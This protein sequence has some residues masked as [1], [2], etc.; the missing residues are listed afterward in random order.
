MVLEKILESPLDSKE[1]KP[2]NPKG[3]QPW[4]FI[5]RTDAEAETPVL[6]PPDAKNW[7]IGKDPDAGNDWR[8]EKGMTEDEMVGW[9]HRLNGH[10]F[11]QAPGDREAWH[12]AIHG[13]ANSQTQLSNWTTTVHLYLKEL[14]RPQPTTTVSLYLSSLFVSF[15]PFRAPYKPVYL[16]L[17][18]LFIFMFLLLERQAGPQPHEDHD[19]KGLDPKRN[20]EPVK[21]FK[22]G[23]KK[24]GIIL[25]IALWQNKWRVKNSLE[26]CK[27]GSPIRRLLGWPKLGVMMRWM[28]RW[29]EALN[30]GIEGWI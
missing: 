22:K 20:A 26:R 29:I 2:V 13:S 14:L 9:H 10:E 3:N 5:G 25:A 16:F 8:Q 18:L 24:T 27:R 30:W 4:I 19:E 6:W 7:L 1:I 28:R 12:V 11:E 23:R 15:T 17:G 21:S